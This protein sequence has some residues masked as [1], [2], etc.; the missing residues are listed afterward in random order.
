MRDPERIKRILDLVYEIWRKQPDTRFMQLI[1]NLSWDYS[2]QNN[3][4]FKE[5]SYSKWETDKGI[6]FTKDVV[7]VDCFH[8]EDD[9]FEKFLIDKLNKN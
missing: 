4:K 2:I 9:K 8:L 3:D 6:V 7:N 1:H 5:Y